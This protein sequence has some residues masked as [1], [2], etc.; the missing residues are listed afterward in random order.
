MPPLT[1]DDQS[2]EVLKTAAS[3]LPVWKRKEFLHAVARELEQVETIG[4]GTVS[5]IA[6]SVQKRILRGESS[7]K[8]MRFQRRAD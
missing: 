2:L 4:A 3:P 6:Q 5:R 8:R 7:T 1:L